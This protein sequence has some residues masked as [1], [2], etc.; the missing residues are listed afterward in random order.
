M[1]APSPFVLQHSGSAQIT[2]TRDSNSA[3]GTLSVEFSTDSAS[4]ESA[5]A[6]TIAAASAGR[7]Y[8]P[9]DETVTF[10]PG[11]TALTVSVPILPNAANPGIVLVGV[12]TKPLVAGGIVETR[13]FAIVSGPD[14]F[15]LTITNAQVVK[16]AS[17]ASAIALTFNEPM[18]QASVENLRNYRITP[19]GR[20][21]PPLPLP[22][23][24]ATYDAATYTVT[25]VTKKPL[26]PARM[27]E[28]AVNT[29]L[30]TTTRRGHNP[31]IGDL[32]SQTGNSLSLVTPQNTSHNPQAPSLV[33][34][35]SN[36]I[37]YLTESFPVSF[38]IS[39]RSSGPP[40]LA[41]I[42]LPI[43]IHVPW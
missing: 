16:E 24:S 12:T 1:S 36:I 40:R 35:P 43:H 29:G 39:S 10:Q 30:L 2:L 17:G 22:L 13:E 11:Q 18:A 4:P 6:K 5:P 41:E 37:G 38:D 34:L 28:V 25:L 27:Y 20:S 14:Q 15:P 23:Q 26:N 19:T 9:V 31:P 3:Q 42:M 33:F 8:L 21:A 32:T 7:Q